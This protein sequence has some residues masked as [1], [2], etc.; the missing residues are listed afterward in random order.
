MLIRLLYC[1]ENPSGA[2]H[3]VCQ[4]ALPFSGCVSGGLS[5]FSR[6]STTYCST[7][8]AAAAA[9]AAMMARDGRGP[10][11]SLESHRGH[12]P[13]KHHV[14]SYV[15]LTSADRSGLL[16]RTDIITAPRRISRARRF[17]E[18]SGTR[19]R[20]G[21]QFRCMGYPT[22]IAASMQ[23]RASHTKL[24]QRCRSFRESEREERYCGMDFIPR[25]VQPE[26]Q[27]L[28]SPPSTRNV[29]V[30]QLYETDKN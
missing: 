7:G 24:A 8:A 20:R 3:R 16:L 11:E 1:Y 13:R 21:R 18:A 14:R 29:P 12:P 26:I 19:A 2:R 25:N 22:R 6:S 5:S 28:L 10:T 15:R 4:P 23:F 27:L 17:R 30:Y 9:A